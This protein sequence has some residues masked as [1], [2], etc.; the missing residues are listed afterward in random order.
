MTR[1]SLGLPL[2]GLLALFAAPVIAAETGAGAAGGRVPRLAADK[3]DSVVNFSLLDYRGKYYELRRADA[4][5][6][7]LY[8]VGLDC[9]IARQSVGKVESLQAEFKAKGLTFWLI[10]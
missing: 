8:F 5:V 4:R 2:I 7:V 6:V 1:I 10:N 3:A 9:P